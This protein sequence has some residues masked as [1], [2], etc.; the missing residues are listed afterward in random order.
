MEPKYPSLKDDKPY[1]DDIQDDVKLPGVDGGNIIEE[2]QESQ[3]PQTIE[4]DNLDITKPDPCPIQLMPGNDE[5][6][7]VPVE[8]IPEA[9]EAQEETPAL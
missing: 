9:M 2:E 1:E 4:I 6:V 3:A 7:P 8:P 5:S